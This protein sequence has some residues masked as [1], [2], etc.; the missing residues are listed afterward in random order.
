[1]EVGCHIL[2][3]KPKK[4]EQGKIRDEYQNSDN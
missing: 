1:M 2:G 3:I 4:I